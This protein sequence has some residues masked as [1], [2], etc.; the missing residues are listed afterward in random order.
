MFQ[1][2]IDGA[3]RGNPGLAGIGIIVYNKSYRVSAYREFIGIRTNNQAEYCALKRAL[4]MTNLVAN[5]L[6]ILSD[7]ILVVNQR[8]KKYKIRNNELKVISREITNLENLFESIEYRHISRSGN[9]EAD[10]EANRAIDDYIK[11]RKNDDL[12]G[13]GDDTELDQLQFLKDEEKALD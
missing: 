2:L 9:M 8:L 4:Q 11:Y 6:V 10:L 13:S 5:E 7:S 3:S 1:V 12:V